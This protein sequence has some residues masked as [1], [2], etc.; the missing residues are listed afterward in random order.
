MMLDIY[1]KILKQFKK[2]D[3]KD[4]NK[5][6]GADMTGKTLVTTGRGRTV[7]CLSDPV[8]VWKHSS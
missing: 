2:T 8:S 3:N 4:T 1:F 5:Q 7:H 6:G